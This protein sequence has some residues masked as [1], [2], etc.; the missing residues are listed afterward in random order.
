[1]KINEVLC[2][3]D[4]RPQDAAWVTK[5]A[6]DLFNQFGIDIAFTNHF[7]ER[8]NDERLDPMYTKQPGW[9]PQNISARELAKMFYAAY[10]AERAKNPQY[11]PIS[12]VPAHGEVVLTDFF[13]KINIPLVVNSKN[14][15]GETV[16]AKTI[17]RKDNFV[18]RNG[19][20][21][22]KVTTK[23]IPDSRLGQTK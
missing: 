23:N 11:K 22:L 2:E 7:W 9:L 5:V 6:N 20:P 17:M 1:M 3:R 15:N 13:S 10:D 4:I 21:K 16:V 18:P 14:K 19:Q 12:A 8:C